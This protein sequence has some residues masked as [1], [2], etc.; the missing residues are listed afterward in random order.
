MQPHQWQPNQVFVFGSNTAGEHAGGAAAF[1]SMNCD[2]IKGIGEG[3]QG[4]SYAI[5]TC[6][7][8]MGGGNGVVLTLDEV[9]R[10]VNRFIVYADSFP[11]LTFFVTRIGCGI[12]G[13]T[14]EQIAPLFTPFAA[15]HRGMLDNLILPPEWDDL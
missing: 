1:A 6:T 13:F 9:E 3:R 2:A 8:S 14:D 11:S 12:A 7:R 15:S 5:P 4:M 10:A